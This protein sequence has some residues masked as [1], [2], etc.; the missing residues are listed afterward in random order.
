MSVFRFSVLISSPAGNDLLYDEA[1]LEQGRNFCNKM[2]NA[3]KL[4][5]M[6]ESRTDSSVNDDEVVFAIN[7]MEN[8]LAQVAGEV[9]ELMKD[10]R[11][12]EGLKT[13]YS[14]I[15][16]DFC[17]W[18]LEWVKPGFE[19][20][21]SEQVYDRTVAIYEQLLQLLHPYWEQY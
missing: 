5:K 6:W 17:S 7:W 14:L 3:L 10:F 19:Q 21:M 11:L 2:W 18:Y 9:G 13:I 1:M 12:S 20:P 15:W 4:I 8:R 16:N